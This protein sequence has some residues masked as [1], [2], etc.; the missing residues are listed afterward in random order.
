MFFKRRF[1]FQTGT[2]FMY[3]YTHFVISSIYFFFI[4]VCVL[5]RRYPSPPSLSFIAQFTDLKH[6]ISL[7]ITLIHSDLKDLPYLFE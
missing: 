3:Y 1:S 4:V 7:K 2:V 5:P 6:A